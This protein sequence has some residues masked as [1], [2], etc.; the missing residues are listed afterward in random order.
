VGAH[1]GAGMVV[2]LGSTNGRGIVDV[3][4]VGEVGANGIDGLRF[5]GNEAGDHLGAAVGF[6][7]DVTG[8][9]LDDILLGAPNADPVPQGGGA[10]II[11]AG[12]VYLVNGY[13][14]GGGPVR[15]GIVDVDRVGN[16]IAGTVL[17]G[18]L[19]NQNA[20]AAL[21]GLGDFS[22]DG[23]P[24]FAI[25]SPG[26]DDGATNTGTV[27]VV[28]EPSVPP[29]GLCGPAGCTVADLGNGARL[30]VPAGSL[31]SEATLSVT[32]I[33]QTSALPAPPPAAKT[34]VAAAGFD[35]EGRTFALPYPFADLPVRQEVDSQIGSGESF[36][37]WF[38]NGSD[39]QDSG[40]DGS[41][42]A[43]V[44][45]GGRKSVRFAPGTLHVYAAFFDDLDGDG[46]RDGLDPDRDGDGAANGAD[47]CPGAPNPNQRNC[48]GDGLG[49]ACDPDFVD[50]DADGWANACDN[51]PV[52]RNPSQSDLDQDGLGDA[53]EASAILRVSSNPADDPDFSSVQAA[54]VAAPTG[55]RIEVRP[56]LGPYVEHILLS[57]G[58]P[59]RIVGS[60]PAHT[61][62]PIVI[63]G[64]TGTAV[65]V[66]PSV[67]GAHLEGLTLRGAT[68]VHASSATSLERV[69]FESISG[70]ALDL[71]AG[72]HTARSVTM[73]PTVASGID[74]AVGASLRL[75]L[76]QLRGQT[77]AAMTVRGGAIVETSLVAD[78][79]AAGIVLIPGASLELRHT[80]IA[81]NTLAGVDS[82]AGSAVSVAHS[83]LWGN[84]AGDLLGVPCAAISWSDTG[85]PGCT[86]IN[87]NLSVNPLFAGGGDYRLS[88]GSALFDHGPDPSSFQGD[89][90]LDL[91]GGP[92]LRDAD[93]D[94]LARMD[95]GAY[96]RGIP[97][98][99]GPVTGLSWSGSTLLSWSTEPSAASYHVYRGALG[100]L[101]YGAFAPCRDDL[102]PARTD[103][104]LSDAQTP[105]AGQGYFYAVTAED[106]AGV[107]GS[108]GLAT[109]A[110]RSSF[111]PCP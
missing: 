92:R 99:P 28:L 74:V 76:A 49:D 72:D 88:A 26:S 37:I 17:T 45:Y 43:N 54:V 20:G 15:R 12:A 39:W 16:E 13:S 103:T 53:C 6:A 84:G 61:G 97:R 33:T 21:S 51:C 90:C 100:S 56:G 24:D 29:P 58:A 78:S 31:A 47:N 64:G 44:Y 108:L 105:L 93:G 111:T 81:G 80:T 71:D 11:D 110:E 32:G 42:V 8:D 2:Q 63:D 7:G 1:E 91:D 34:L 38:W 98:V 86:G 27:Y 62:S 10:P 77:G 5:N 102:D 70:T 60:D 19:A 18:T 48:D 75:D 52:R 95:P 59:I 68:G 67:A 101:T 35:D 107:E 65:D 57:A 23:V 40:L 83:I 106:G 85:S 109:C 3:D 55:G 30:D 4:R 9:G 50:T 104:V 87:S 66:G 36:D 41:A 25:G 82:T 96:E 22:G 14:V 46:V 79:A 69:A 89:P 73:G 94:G